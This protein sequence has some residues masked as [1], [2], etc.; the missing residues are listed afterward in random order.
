MRLWMSVAVIVFDSLA[1][2]SLVWCGF[3]AHQV[4][5]GQDWLLPA[6]L[7]PATLYLWLRIG[8]S[9]AELL[10]VMFFLIGAGVFFFVGHRYF[11]VSNG[12]PDMM[13]YA[14]CAAASLAGFRTWQPAGPTQA[15]GK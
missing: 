7:I 1:W 15:G 2:L 12:L 14:L 13:V 11:G 6:F 3:I 4:F 9:T 8:S 10:A 5:S